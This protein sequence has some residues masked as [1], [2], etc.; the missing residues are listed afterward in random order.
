MAPVS[1]RTRSVLVRTTQAATCQAPPVISTGQ[2]PITPVPNVN[3]RLDGDGAA[4]VRRISHDARDRKTVPASH[5]RF[6]EP[7][8]CDEATTKRP[9]RRGP[10]L[11]SG[12]G[13]PASAVADPVRAMERRHRAWLCHESGP[14]GSVDIACPSETIPQTSGPCT[15][16]SHAKTQ[17]GAVSSPC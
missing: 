10:I 16:L 9:V 1:R 8:D 4:D 13:G 7:V 6:T 5:P 12:F 3:R 2:H 14:L 11:S 17:N 15:H